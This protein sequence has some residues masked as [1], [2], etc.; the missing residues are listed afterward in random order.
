[1][2]IFDEVANKSLS[3]ITILLKR[4]EIIQL[5]GYLEELSSNATENQHYHL[6]DDTYFKEITIAVY[7]KNGKLDHFAEKYRKLILSDD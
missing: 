4:N 5:I 7:D 1:M 2:K 3:N 6:N